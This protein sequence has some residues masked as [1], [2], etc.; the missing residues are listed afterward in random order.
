M[1]ATRLEVPQSPVSPLV[2]EVSQQL[3][4]SGRLRLR[5]VQ[6]NEDRGTVVLTGSVPTFYLKQL[7]QT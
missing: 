1:Q 4:G 2:A 6:V 5:G 7:A 3:V